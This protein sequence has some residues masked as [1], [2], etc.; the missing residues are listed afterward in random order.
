MKIQTNPLIIP[1]KHRVNRKWLLI[2]A[3]IFSF[4]ISCAM[5]HTGLNI[6]FTIQEGATEKLQRSSSIV[7]LKPKIEFALRSFADDPVVLPDVQNQIRNTVSGALSRGLLDRGYTTAPL[8]PI[9]SLSLLS[10][11]RLQESY[12]RKMNLRHYTDNTLPN[13]G[14]SVNTLSA[15]SDADLLVM[16][17]Y[18]GSRLTLNQ[19]RKD[20]FTALMRSWISL[21]KQKPMVLPQEYGELELAVIDGITGQIYWIAKASAMPEHLSTQIEALLGTM[22]LK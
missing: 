16:S 3:V 10:L 17:R 21:G 14:P 4:Q 5:V 2:G 22:P 6:D 8:G 13:L 20:S 7:V 18:T 12:Q 19:H 1:I 11:Y 9:Q 15:P